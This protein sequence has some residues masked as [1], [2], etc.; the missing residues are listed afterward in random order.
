MELEQGENV[1]NQINAIGT[2]GERLLVTVHYLA[3]L[4]ESQQDA[5]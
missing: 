3:D 2:I 5:S 1:E 4:P